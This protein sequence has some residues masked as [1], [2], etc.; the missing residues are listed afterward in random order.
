MERPHNDF[1]SANGHI[2]N[3]KNNNNTNYNSHNDNNNQKSKIFF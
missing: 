3:I 1:L 2:N